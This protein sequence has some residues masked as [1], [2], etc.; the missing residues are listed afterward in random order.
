[1]SANPSTD[2][3]RAKGWASLVREK[4]VLAQFQLEVFSKVEKKIRRSVFFEE[5]LAREPAS[6]AML[7]MYRLHCTSRGIK[8]VYMRI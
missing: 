2:L 8:Y 6:R 7:E 4:F 1:M 3:D 5:I